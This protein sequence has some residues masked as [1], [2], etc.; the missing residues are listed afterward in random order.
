MKGRKEKITGK[1]SYSSFSLSDMSLTQQKLAGQLG[2]VQ[3][4]SWLQFFPVHELS[5][6]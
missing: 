2:D 1:Q 6:K 5:K 4:D 3:Q